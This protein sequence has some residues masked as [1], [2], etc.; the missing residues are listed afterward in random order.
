MTVIKSTRDFTAL[1]LV[2][3][4]TSE[5]CACAVKACDGWETYKAKWAL[6]QHETEGR[7]YVKF[8]TGRRVY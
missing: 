4:A 6:R 5:A 1:P 8:L 2:I 3:E 7:P